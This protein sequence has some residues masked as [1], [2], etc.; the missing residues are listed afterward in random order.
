VN[1][2]KGNAGSALV[3]STNKTKTN[4]S[5]RVASS[6]GAQSQKPKKPNATPQEGPT[7][8][9]ATAIEEAKPL[10]VAELKSDSEQL[11]AMLGLPG[12]EMPPLPI[13]EHDD[14]VKDFGNAETNTIVIK[15]TDDDRTAMSKENV[16]WVKTYIA[17]AKRM[18]WTPAQYIQELEKTRKLEALQRNTAAQMMA[19]IEREYPN[20][21][22]AAR[23]ELNKELLEKGLKPLDEPEAVEP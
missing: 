6:K 3:A 22:T 5:N 10:P 23:A 4:N 20:D 11:I 2:A 9:S 13:P 18:G 8:A 1:A 12:E 16:A 17:E 19:E 15:E 14:L 7:I 21:V